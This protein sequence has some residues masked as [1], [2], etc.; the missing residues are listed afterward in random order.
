M[1]GRKI[2]EFRM[3]G[4][5]AITDKIFESKYI[6]FQLHKGLKGMPHCKHGGRD[7]GIEPEVSLE[8][9]KGSNKTDDKR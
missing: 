4:P 1:E 7:V 3:R 6:T 8:A 9:N 2:K 5:K